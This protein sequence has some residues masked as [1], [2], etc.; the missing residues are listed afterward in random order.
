MTMTP[1]KIGLGAITRRRPEML[2]DLLE[3]YS[4][5]AIPEGTEVVVL[6]AENDSEERMREIIDGWAA[7]APFEVRYALETE[8]GIPFARNRVLDMAHEEGC[9]FLTFV[10]D[11]ERVRPDWLVKIYA[12][13][14]ERDLDLV[15]GPL[16]YVAPEGADLTLQQ[17]AV[18]H[19]VQARARKSIALRVEL[20]ETPRET[21]LGIYTNN[22]LCRLSAQSRLGIR[23]DESLRFTGGS[24][25]KFYSDMREAG[26]R[27]GWSPDA[28]V[29]ET[30]PLERLTYRYHFQRNRDQETA[31]RLR[32]TRRRR[33]VAAIVMLVVNSIRALAYLLAAPF[34]RMRTVPLAMR[35]FGKGVGR[36]KA[37]LGINS[38]LY[39]PKKID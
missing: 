32:D 9:D 28:F 4:A 34:T 7:D 39:H 11:D 22:W 2:A 36:V 30:R 20:T 24:D 8:P 37:A 12:T 6:I 35:A 25:T 19:E 38:S 5:L 13:I 27:V 15:G 21:H 10:D 29:D 26:A 17:S 23:F 1:V 3:S 31:R 14:V 33:P 16:W 18:L